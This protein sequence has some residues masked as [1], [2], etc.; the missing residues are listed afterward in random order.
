MNS[1]IGTVIDVWSI[2]AKIPGTLFRNVHITVSL[3]QNH[4][5]LAILCCLFSCFGWPRPYTYGIT[6]TPYM[7][8]FRWCI[9]H[10]YILTFFQ[11]HTTHCY[12]IIFYLASNHQVK[13]DYK[14]MSHVWL[15][16]L[17]YICFS[18][19]YTPH[20]QKQ[21]CSLKYSVLFSH[22][23]QCSQHTLSQT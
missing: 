21:F 1:L 20:H 14:A 15:K 22:L 3:G 17:I 6:C 9:N 18:H 8:H 11:L 23:L 7:K 4:I 10:K 13:Y 19:M 2:R 16:I 12:I 5:H